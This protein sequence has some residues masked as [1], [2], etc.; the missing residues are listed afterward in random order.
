MDI[1][2]MPSRCLL[3][4]G[5]RFESNN[6]MIS[7]TFPVD[8]LSANLFSQSDCATCSKLWFT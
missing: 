5:I 3:D 8:K 4:N 7:S 1:F 6:S 2:S